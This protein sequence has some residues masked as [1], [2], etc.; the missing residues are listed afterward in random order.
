MKHG[1]VP[2]VAQRKHIKSFRMN[3]ENWLV[4]KDTIDEMVIV[5]RLTETKRVLPG[6]KR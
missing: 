4:V 2:T 5:H 1:K 6:R 3:P